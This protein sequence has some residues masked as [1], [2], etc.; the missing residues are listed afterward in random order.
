MGFASGLPGA[1]STG[2]AAFEKCYGSDKSQWPFNTN[3]CAYNRQD[4]SC[5]TSPS[6]SP[7]PGPSPPPSPPS[8]PSPTPPSPA[9]STCSAA[10]STSC[11]QYIGKDLQ[12]CMEC[13]R[14]NHAT[15]IKSC[16]RGI[17]DMRTA[18]QGGVVV[19]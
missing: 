19:V 18:C 5:S 3:C 16:P 15:L 12:S 8:P 4:I 17:T 7:G 10:V 14:T 13:C 6:P 1:I 9:P 2:Q 11:G